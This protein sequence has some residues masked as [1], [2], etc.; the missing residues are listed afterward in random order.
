MHTLRASAKQTER[1]KTNQKENGIIHQPI[2]FTET[3]GLR[4]GGKTFDADA[5][6]D[7]HKGNV[8]HPFL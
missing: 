5:D 7:A 3:A 6:F 8:W 2:L 1:P 4:P